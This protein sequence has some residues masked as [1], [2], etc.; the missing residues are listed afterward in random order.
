MAC[1]PSC[2]WSVCLSFFPASSAVCSVRVVMSE[3]E[4]AAVAELNSIAQLLRFLAGMFFAY[5]AFRFI[6]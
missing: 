4:I 2:F 6:E 3:F 5:A 1:V